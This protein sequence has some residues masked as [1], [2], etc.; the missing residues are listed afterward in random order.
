[1][2]DSVEKAKTP[3]QLKLQK[4]LDALRKEQEKIVSKQASNDKVL[5]STFRSLDDM[6]K[7]M[8]SKLAAFDFEKNAIEGNINRYELQLKQQQAQAAEI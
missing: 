4:K 5:L 2:L 6:N 1:M 3:E 8:E 7:A